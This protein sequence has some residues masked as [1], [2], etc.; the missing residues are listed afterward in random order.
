MWV[1]DEGC[2]S[3]STAA[4]IVAHANDINGTGNFKVFAKIL[5][6]LRGLNSAACDTGVGY[7]VTNASSISDHEEK[8]SNRTSIR[9]LLSIAGICEQVQMDSNKK[10]SKKELSAD[11]QNFDLMLPPR[12]ALEHPDP[13]L[14]VD[15]IDKLTKDSGGMSEEEQDDVASAILRRY[16]SDDNISV[17]SESA[18]ALLKMSSEGTM[19]ELFILQNQVAENIVRGF[20]KTVKALGIMSKRGRIERSPLS[21][22]EAAM[23]CAGLKLSGMIAHNLQTNLDLETLDIEND[24]SSEN[25]FDSY[26][27][28]VQGIVT[29]QYYCD[30]DEG[31]I[32][33]DVKIAAQGAL[34][35]AVNT[36]MKAKRNGA[37][38]DNIVK[39][40]L[41]QIVLQRSI[42][43]LSSAESSNSLERERLLWFF[44]RQTVLIEENDRDNTLVELILDASILLLERYEKKISYTA[45]FA[46]NSSILTKNLETCVSNLLKGGHVDE[47]T[48]LISDLM[49]IRSNETYENVCLNVMALASKI[50]PDLYPHHLFEIVSRPNLTILGTSRA[51]IEIERF[52]R[53]VDPSVCHSVCGTFLVCAIALTC[54]SD[55]GIRESA[56]DLIARLKHLVVDSDSMNAA[57]K[58]LCSVACGSN[59]PMRSNIKMDGS[60]ALP[61]LLRSAVASG[62]KDG[63]ILRQVLLE[64]CAE[65]AT[66]HLLDNKTSF[67]GEGI[68]HSIIL[69]LNAFETAGEK[70]FSLNDRW[71]LAGKPIF[72]HFI[73]RQAAESSEKLDSLIDC[74]VVMLKGVIV[75][76]A[77]E[78]NIIISTGPATSG[79]RRRAYSVSMSS[80]IAFINPYPNDM[81]KSLAQFFVWAV[82]NPNNSFVRQLCEAINRL[83][84]G[85]SSWA[86]GIFSKLDNKTQQIIFT[87]VLALR[88]DG[89]IESAGLVML[90]LPL[91]AGQFVEAI[92]SKSSRASKLDSGGL[93]AL[94]ALTDCIRAQASNLES[95]KGVTKLSS[96]LYD[97]L[98]SLSTQDF[99]NGSD[100]ARTCIIHALLA[101][102]HNISGGTSRKSSEKKL[103]K[104]ID[105]QSKLL[106]SLLGGEDANVKPLVSS[107]SMSLCLQL[108]THLCSISPTSVVGSLIPAL[109]NAISV[110]A[111]GSNVVRDALMAV[112]PSYCEHAQIGGSS[113]FTFFQ[114]FAKKCEAGK[115]SWDGKVQMY[116]SLI[117]AFMSVP[118][119]NSGAGVT[120]SNVITIY[121]ASQALSNQDTVMEE[122]EESPINFVEELLSN[123]DPDSKISATLP[124]LKYVG[125]LL[126]CLDDHRQ[127]T[128]RGKSF[129]I[130]EVADICGLA[131]HGPSQSE[132]TKFEMP[133]QNEQK[134]PITWCVMTILSVVKNIYSDRKVK[135]VI[136]HGNDVQA[137][138]CLS[139]WQELVALQ[140]VS[141]HSRNRESNLKDDTNDI[142]DHMG[143]ETSGILSS[144][145]NLLPAPHFLASV[146]SLINDNDVEIDIQRRAIML[147]AER[148]METDPTSHEAVL[149]LEMLPDL[150]KFARQGTNEHSNSESSRHT[151]IRSQTS[152]KAIDQLSKS[153]GMAIVDDKLRR[154]RTKLFMPALQAS[155]A[156][157]YRI[158]TTFKIPSNIG[159]AE[160]D[161]SSFQMETQVLSSAALCAASLITLLK[162]KALTV[163]PTL[164]KPLIKLLTAVNACDATTI[165]DK[166]SQ[167][168][169]TQSIRLIQLSTLRCL[170]AVSDHIPQFL[171]PYV[172]G[173]LT[174]HGLPS[175]RLRG[176]GSEEE[177]AVN[178]M[179]NRLDNS[180]ASGPPVR[181]LIP[182]LSKSTAKCLKM[183]SEGEPI[184]QESLIIFKI[185][186][187]C[188]EK[189]TRS[190][191]GPLAG[192]IISSLVQA[193]AFD[194]DM[195]T[196]I[197]LIDVANETLLAMVMKLSEAQLRPLYAKLRDWRGDLNASQAD[198]AA[199]RRRNA[200]WSLSAA[201]SKELRSI[202][203]PCMNSVVGDVVEE[204]V[205]IQSKCL[206]SLHFF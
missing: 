121:I 29:I 92:S 49:V 77:V 104:E 185:L 152:F 42:H 44:L 34:L 147:L 168:S 201:M 64:S 143:N 15:A 146:G 174:V 128:G 7:A 108:L 43:D 182:I 192:K 94:T 20:A 54:H 9:E 69:L 145:Q 198:G 131:I 130:I 148:A 39:S 4:Y 183:S 45:E 6:S 65:L 150:V 200:F 80:E 166:D 110:D 1:G 115:D 162:A 203:L 133:Y 172:D 47:I 70:S 169:I 51:L 74:T 55:L 138:V 59:A 144:L 171:I 21:K 68:C 28:L 31:D 103:T 25:M 41:F 199:A 62:K 30:C 119:K 142:W 79:R 170:V 205:S 2:L 149:F 18:K 126:Q 3:A 187:L 114:A 178:G 188:I 107:K 24:Y 176:I 102:V 141:S 40:V 140:S 67:A 53:T 50:D 109:M 181:Q 132:S 27:R 19:S 36:E 164:V 155:A 76:N 63:S 60:N 196:R 61:K 91:T 72:D 135:H 23:L 184:W 78:D 16:A 11:T 57:F 193:Y 14:R 10:K 32:F 82:A 73:T 161:I 86:N 17:V 129:F 179:A 83:V 46:E 93:L 186:K 5:K 12:I 163:L 71:C 175:T 120:I 8:E 100:Y 87:S 99:V 153:L 139:I 118:D 75:D 97:K 111:A 159:G 105:S 194:C 127:S 197:E 157:L 90:G 13:K 136:R 156:Y 26:D 89:G 85:R 123:L 154:K 52:V 112:V 125:E 56:L 35:S 96:I 160:A 190:D 33:S 95:D 48:K 122:D 206:N 158:A 88:S 202:F 113:L 137:K 124:L 22:D 167:D 38:M 106:V 134:I 195:S 189:A 81:K 191:L 180:L 116:N 173:L 177:L 37:A 84:L 101:I 66:K 151:S 98:S 204:L 117:D 58:C 165:K